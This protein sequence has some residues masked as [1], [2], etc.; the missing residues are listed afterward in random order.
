MARYDEITESNWLTKKEKQIQKSVNSLLAFCLIDFVLLV[1]RPVRVYHF[2]DFPNMHLIGV[3]L[4]FIMVWVRI[5]QAE[6]EGR[7]PYMEGSRCL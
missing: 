1:F 7:N 6:K 4:L 3:V 5:S 2:S